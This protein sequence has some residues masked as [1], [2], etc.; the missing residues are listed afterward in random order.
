M[1]PIALEGRAGRLLLI[2][3]SLA[4][5]LV[6]SATAEPVQE[7]DDIF[8]GGAQFLD[9]GRACLVDGDGNL[10]IAGETNDLV[11][12]SEMSIRMLER[13][14]GETL[15]TTEFI[16][17]DGSDMAVHGIV[18]DS[19]GDILLGGHVLGCEG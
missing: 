7:W 9:I 11:A 10:I 8:D 13:D 6:V 17:L 16:A 3:G 12:G 4:G 5:L 2:V 15:W 19:A 14:T 1:G 18:H